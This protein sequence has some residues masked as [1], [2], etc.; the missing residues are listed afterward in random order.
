MGKGIRDWLARCRLIYRRR[1]VER[2]SNGDNMTAIYSIE[3]TVDE[4]GIS[5][6]D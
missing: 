4:P 6:G 2:K 1:P 3:S 5:T